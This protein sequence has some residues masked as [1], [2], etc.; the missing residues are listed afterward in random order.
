MRVVSLYQRH[1]AQDFDSEEDDGDEG[2]EEDEDEDG[3]SLV[4]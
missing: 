3:A 1:T 2:D 4:V